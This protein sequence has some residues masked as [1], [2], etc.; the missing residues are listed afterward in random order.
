MRNIIEPEQNIYVG[1]LHKLADGAGRISFSSSGDYKE[2]L[3]GISR[4]R[5]RLFSIGLKMVL[6]YRNLQEMTDKEV[7]ERNGAPF[8]Q[9]VN[10]DPVDTK[11]FNM[12]CNICETLKTHGT[13][14][15]E[16]VGE[17]RCLSY[18]RNMKEGTYRYLLET[19]PETILQ[20][21]S[22]ELE[23]EGL[24]PEKRDESGFDYKKIINRLS[25]I[26][27]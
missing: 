11:L 3:E 5:A 4:C 13:Y 24:N 20:R 21:L 9:V 27:I 26:L 14:L 8:G 22:S 2:V 25:S 15:E 16:L 23:S 18:Q 10:S 7:K 12:S 17:I 1:Y 6:R 19:S